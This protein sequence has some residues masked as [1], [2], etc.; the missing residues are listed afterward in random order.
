MLVPYNYLPYQFENTKTIFKE[1]KKLIK[2]TDF[3]LGNKMKEFEKKFS[4]YI[5]SKYCIST[6]NGTDPLILSLKSLGIQ[7]G[8]EI[9]IPAHTYCASAIPFLRNGARIVWADID[10]DTRVIDF[11]D[12]QKKISKKTKAIVV[13][14]IIIFNIKV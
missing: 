1:W 8:D 12:V 4:Q 11:Q 9:I 14:M 2:T 6:N 13:K 5:G 10:F 7:K 3:T